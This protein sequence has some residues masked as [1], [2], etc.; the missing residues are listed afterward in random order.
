MYKY[1]SKDP[2]HLFTSGQ[3]FTTKPCVSVVYSFDFRTSSDFINCIRL[4]IHRDTLEHYWREVANTCNQVYG[5]S[6][7]H[8]AGPIASPPHFQPQARNVTYWSLVK[9][10]AA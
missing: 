2:F 4:L 3:M 7:S 10:L 5:S 8:F 9:P 6:K 1:L